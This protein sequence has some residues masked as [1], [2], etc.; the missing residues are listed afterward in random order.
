MTGRSKQLVCF[1]KGSVGKKCLQIQEREGK[2]D[3]VSS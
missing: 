1:K 3:E 2:S